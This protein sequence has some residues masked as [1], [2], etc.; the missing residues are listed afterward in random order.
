MINQEVSNQPKKINK[1]LSFGGGL[2]TGFL[3]GFVGSGGGF[4]LVPVL[5]KVGNL[6]VKAAVATSIGIIA[7]NTSVGFMASVSHVEVNWM[8]L[9][10]FSLLAIL[11][12]LIGNNLSKKVNSNHL[13][14]GFGWFILITGVVILVNEFFVKQ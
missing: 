2:A 1:A 3:S 4:M 12:I 9:V 11:G 13:K 8:L 6:G 7:L 14:K 5:I 10:V